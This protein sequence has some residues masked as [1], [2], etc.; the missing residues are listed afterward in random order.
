[1]S[2]F[3]KRKNIAVFFFVFF[4]FGLL[5]CADTLAF[6]ERFFKRDE[7]IEINGDTVIYDSENQIYYAEGGVVI[8][9]AETTLKADRVV[10]DMRSGV[11]IAAGNV[12]ASDV[13]GN[14]LRGET[15]TLD[16]NNETASVAPGRFFVKEGNV[17]VFADVIRKTGKMSFDADNTVFTTCDCAEG[18]SAPWSFTTSYAKFG[19]GGIFTAWNAFFR[20]KDVPVFYTPFIAA[21][22]T[23]KRQTGFL[24]PRFGYS[25]LRGVKIDNAFFWA[26]SDSRDFTL[27]LDV[28]TKRGVGEG[29]EY[30]YFRTGRS[31]GEFY[32]YHFEED[33][34][35]RVRGFRSDVNN[36]LRPP[37]ADNNRWE[38]KASHREYLSD[39]IVLRAGI[40]VVSDD[41]YFMDFSKDQRERSKESLESSASVTK[42]WEAYS[43]AAQFRVFDN[44]FL[45]ND[46]T[47]V[48]VLPE[49]LFAKESRRVA[50]LPFF[51]SFD[52]SLVNF[53]RKEGE[54][55]QRLD[56]RPGISFPLK[57]GG[58]LELTPSFT[59]M[60][61]AYGVDGGDYRGKILYEFKMD[62]VTTFVRYF[63]VKREGM[64]KLRHTIRPRLAYA[65]IPP[66]NQ[67]R[68]PEFDSVDRIPP[69]NSILYSIN[70]TISGKGVDGTRR[71]ML[72]LDIS[73]SFSVRE[74]RGGGGRPLSDINAEMVF[75]LFDRASFNAKGAYD[76]YDDRF[77]KYDAA[78]SLK[79]KRGDE[80]S[81]TRRFVRDSADYLD[82]NAKMM[83]TGS[84]SLGFRQRYSF[85]DSESIER[86]YTF[87]FTRQCWGAE[88]TYTEKFEENIVFLAFN[89]KGIGELL[90]TSVGMAEK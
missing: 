28:E 17:Y 8:V 19:T 26:I 39:S 71:D 74:A 7:P 12:E 41:E 37:S 40:D 72:Y 62:A 73:Q 59:P 63:D 16:M 50:T 57:P 36:F 45:E 29:M 46:D 79:D 77:E 33:D 9:Q 38:L 65:Y 83:V 32:L 56:L 30:R 66:S 69:L 78:L 85:K 47:V 24:F 68:L 55:G 52:S 44:L 70:S 88:L 14:Y 90:S 86:G 34:I 42:N 15:F 89:L 82:A 48:Q 4:A 25:D 76:V 23:K 58:L 18:A 31:Y 5:R 60:F 22:V 6:D 13:S 80:F 10:M 35:D 2:G 54:K 51:L 1:M 27:Y 84:V 61:T 64:E 11:A 53:Y 21:P 87:F 81:V 3:Y 49:V 67:A 43:L 20:I 75:N